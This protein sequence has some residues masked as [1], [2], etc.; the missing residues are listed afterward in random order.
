VA[1]TQKIP[2]ISVKLN[3]QLQDLLD[4]SKVI[5]SFKKD[6]NVSPNKILTMAAIL[7]LKN[8]VINGWVP[9]NIIERIEKTDEFDDLIDLKEDEQ[10]ELFKLYDFSEFYFDRGETKSVSV[11]VPT[12]IKQAVQNS[13]NWL[14]LSKKD[15][16]CDGDFVLRGFM[17]LIKLFES[18]GEFE[19]L[20]QSLTKQKEILATKA[21]RRL[22]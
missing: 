3:E 4:Q 13:K 19:R 10:I 12:E 1:T 6:A 14:F 21:A 20:N 7:E 17:R 16:I 15:N 5:L 2:A 8:C 11:K 18:R 22:A 9:E